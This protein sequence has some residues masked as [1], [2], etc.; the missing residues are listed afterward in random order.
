MGTTD[1]A[2]LRWTARSTAQNIHGRKAAVLVCGQL[3]H[4]YMKPLVAN[5]SPATMPASLDTPRRRKN[6]AMPAMVTSVTTSCDHAGASQSGRI[7]YGQVVGE[8][9]ATSSMA[10]NGVPPLLYG[11]QEGKSPSHSRSTNSAVSGSITF[12]WSPNHVPANVQS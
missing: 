7:M 12:T 8:N 3:V 10:P 4:T 6:S 5:A 9:T 11:D 2:R 1:E